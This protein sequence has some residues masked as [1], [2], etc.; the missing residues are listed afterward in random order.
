MFSYLWKA[1]MRRNV[2]KITCS[3]SNCTYTW[4]CSPMRTRSNII[5]LGRVGTL[6]EKVVGCLSRL[7]ITRGKHRI[8]AGTLPCSSWRVFAQIVAIKVEVL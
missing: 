1:H 7:K 3:S 8:S 4:N 6:L 2:L 5:I